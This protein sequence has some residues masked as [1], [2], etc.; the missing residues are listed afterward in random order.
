MGDFRKL[1]VWQLSK[2]VAVEIY[3]EVNSSSELKKDFRLASQITS[4]AVSVASN[5]AEGDELDTV[6]QANRHF[7]IAKGSA[8]EVIT[9]LI[10][11]KE[12]GY[13]KEEKVDELVKKVNIISVSLYKLIKARKE[14]KN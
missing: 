5:I 10:I 1:R 4:A 6:K 9:Q 7:Y 14:W 13:L 12:I 3:K 2:D 11:C 8:A